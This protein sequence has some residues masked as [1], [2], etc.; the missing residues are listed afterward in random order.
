MNGRNIYPTPSSRTIHEGAS[1]KRSDNGSKPIRQPQVA[2]IGGYLWWVTKYRDEGE[3]A[4]I[5]P[6]TLKKN[7]SSA[8]SVRDEEDIDG[9]VYT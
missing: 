7:W 1:N 5:H 3:R 4:Q 6:I 9:R 8:S 2:H